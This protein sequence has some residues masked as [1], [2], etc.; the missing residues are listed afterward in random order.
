MMETG[1]GYTKVARAEAEERTRIA[2]LDAADDAFLCGPW[3]E[4]S[5]EAIAGAAGFTKQTLLRHFGS[6]DGLLE[7]TLRRAI[8][9]VEEQRLGAP[10]HDIAG[11]VE[12][13]LSHYETRGGRAMRSSNLSLEGPL[14]D[15]GRRAREF[16]YDWVDHAFGTSLAAA[17]SAQ[18]GRLRAALITVC[19]VQSWWILS[20]DL[21]LPRAEVRAT[22]ILTISRLLGEDS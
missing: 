22:L 16:H 11:A 13:L 14:A 7:K 20:H 17:E 8:A 2:L 19:D 4:A 18:R 9:E 10:A 1:R 12:N 3:E 21:G 6:K 15:L 5:L